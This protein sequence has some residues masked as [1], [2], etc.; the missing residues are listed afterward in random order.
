MALADKAG[1]CP[2]AA[3]L[4]EPLLTAAAVRAILRLGP[5]SRLPGSLPRVRVALRSVRFP[6][7]TLRRW[8]LER[9]AGWRASWQNPQCDDGTPQPEATVTLEP[10]LTQSEVKTLLGLSKW[11]TVS[12]GVSRVALGRFSYRY[13]RV[14]VDVWLAWQ[15][16]GGQTYWRR[17]EAGSTTAPVPERTNDYLVSGHE[18]PEQ[19]VISQPRRRGSWR[20]S[21]G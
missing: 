21:T 20:R 14:A 6:P 16:A 8:I 5:N 17:R 18:R 9:E 10:L 19:G 2:S 13:R 3:G 7:D 11:D 12:S 1:P 4:L 15:S